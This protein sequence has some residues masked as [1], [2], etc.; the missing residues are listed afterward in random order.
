LDRIEDNNIII[1]CLLFGLTDIISAINIAYDMLNTFNLIRSGL[2]MN[3]GG[4]IFNSVNDIRLGD[5]IINQL[6]V[7]SENVI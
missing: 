1:A 3:V 6:N 2:I 7:T 4:G 5:I